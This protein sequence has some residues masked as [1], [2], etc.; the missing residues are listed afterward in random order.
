MSSDSTSDLL[1]RFRERVARAD[2]LPEM[3]LLGIAAGLLTG[4]VMLLFRAAIELPLGAL[5][6]DGSESFEQLSPIT[7]A[8]L[9]VAGSL[10]IGTC[11][12]RMRPASRRV[13][14]VHVLERLARN[15][16]RLPLRNAVVQFVFGAVALLSGH[17]V[18]REGPAVHLGA[19]ASSLVATLLR[20]PNNCV[21]TLIACGSAAAIGASFNTPLAGVIF[22]ME[23][24]L[25][26]YTLTGFLPVI[27]AA[28][29]AT[30]LQQAAYGDQVAFQMPALVMPGFNELPLIVGFGLLIGVL[31][32][33]FVWL[34]QVCTRRGPRNYLGRLVIAGALCGGVAM[35]VPEVMGIGYDTVAAALSGEIAVG[36]LAAIVIAK[37][38]VS[39]VAV[40]L[41][42]PGGVIGPTL[43]V[44]ATAGGLVAALAAWANPGEAISPAL[45][46]TIGMAAMMG[47]VLQ[48]PLAAAL[49]VLELTSNVSIMLPALLAIALATLTSSQVYGR[50]SIF[51]ESLRSL[52]LDLRHDPVTLHLQRT[53]VVSLMESAIVEL[54]ARVETA[55]AR[56]ML[57]AEP[58]WIIVMGGGPLCALRA[59]DLHRYLESERALAPDAGEPELIDL[60][61]IPGLRRDLAT[62]EERATV[63]EARIAFRR[64]GHEA[65]L[66]RRVVSPTD[67]EAVGV[68]TREHLEHFVRQG[69]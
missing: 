63:E 61:D 26:E 48:A 54:P 35:F 21:R 1:A 56:R 15:Q 34:T 65:L 19:A 37:L 45:Y 22:A 68:L 14:V 25:M 60:L 9:P 32:A 46:V 51:L 27:L 8:L 18:G 42:V 57:A 58:V 52:G 55:V 17:S 11:L 13:G 23:V 31:A 36:V 28:V 20:L 4:V 5:L 38:L 64:S 41:Q 6:P 66:I 53:G 67:V 49:A 47:A 29:T 3:S 12:W 43:V 33:V 50:G 7:R 30:L 16:G 39:A 2:A 69:T 44:G 40:G 10:L 59:D 24:V 62:I